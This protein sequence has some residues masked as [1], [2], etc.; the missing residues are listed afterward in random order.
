MNHFWK[1]SPSTTSSSAPKK[2]S[3]GPR[4]GIFW[5][6]WLMEMDYDQIHP[7][8][9]AAWKEVPMP[10]NSTELRSTLSAMPYYHMYIPGRAS[11]LTPLIRLVT[12]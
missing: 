2:R 8:K 4:E 10:S 12:L 3:W 6:I 9:V 7:P 1:G 5:D 11:K